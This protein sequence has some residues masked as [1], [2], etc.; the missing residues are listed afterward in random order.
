MSGVEKNWKGYVWGGKNDGGGNVR[1][2]IYPY[3]SHGY[4][5]LQIT[6]LLVK[7]MDKVFYAVRL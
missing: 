2:G 6:A 1:K 5:P 7:S 4:Y 3:I